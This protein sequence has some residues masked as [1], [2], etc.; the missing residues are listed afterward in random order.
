MI[1]NA[2]KEHDDGH[3]GH[4]KVD[5]PVG[6]RQQQGI[7]CHGR[8]DHHFTK[9]AAKRHRAKQQEVEISPGE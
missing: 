1:I 8:S 9:S 5:L 3:P 7:A 2:G 4:R 6:K